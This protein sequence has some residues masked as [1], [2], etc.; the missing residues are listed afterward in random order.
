LISSMF[1]A[2]VC[3]FATAYDGSVIF[4]AP[5][6]G[7]VL[8]AALNLYIIRLLRK[9]SVLDRFKPN[10]SKHLDAADAVPSV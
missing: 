7:Y 4:L 10:K 2:L 1:L 5:F 9:T 3:L 6:S 8:S